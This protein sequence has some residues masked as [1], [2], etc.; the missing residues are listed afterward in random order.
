L[1][2]WIFHDPRFGHPTCT[3]LEPPNGLNWWAV[4]S[5]KKGVSTGSLDMDEL[6]INYA[7]KNG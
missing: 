1:T 5:W 2:P 7:L 4:F 6:W 3:L